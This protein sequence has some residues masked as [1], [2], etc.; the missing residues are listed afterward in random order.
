MRNE[1]FQKS[2]APELWPSAIAFRFS[3]KFSAL[4]CDQD[5]RIVLHLDNYVLDVDDP[6]L[7]IEL[8]LTYVTVGI[9]VINWIVS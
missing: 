4:H 2:L 7:M 9:A 8:I 3:T 5:S 6:N 1:L